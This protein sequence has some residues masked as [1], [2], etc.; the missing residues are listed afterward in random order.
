[1]SAQMVPELLLF[2][3][4]GPDRFNGTDE[5]SNPEPS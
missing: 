4:C 1:M 3:S 5:Q 2:A